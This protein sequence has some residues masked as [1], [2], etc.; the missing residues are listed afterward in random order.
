MRAR[1]AVPQFES[2][3]AP[4]MSR[5]AVNAAAIRIP[6]RVSS[7]LALVFPTA[8]PQLFVHEGARQSLER[9]LS[10]AFP[11]RVVI[12]SITDNRCSIISHAPKKNGV[13][14]ARI[15]F[16][17]LDAPPRVVNALVRYL[18]SDDRE[19][20]QIVGAYIE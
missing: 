19:A 11:G 7:Q 6:E 16:M 3:L 17:F 5:P 1:K 15:H 12:L 14:H 10:A 9:K 2:W 4:R 8:S 13:V 20:S 18:T